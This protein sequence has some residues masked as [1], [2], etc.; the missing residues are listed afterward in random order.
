[1]LSLWW[2]R[3][4]LIAYTVFPCCLLQNGLKSWR[5]TKC[6][7]LIF[8]CLDF[9]M[10]LYDCEDEFL[11]TFKTTINEVLCPLHLLCSH[12]LDH[13]QILK[14]PANTVK[15]LEL[16]CC[17]NGLPQL[18]FFQQFGLC[19]ALLTCRGCIPEA[20]MSLIIR[21]WARFFGSAGRSRGPG[22]VSSMYWI[23]AS[24][25]S[26]HI[27]CFSAGCTNSLLLLFS[28]WIKIGLKSGG[29]TDWER[30]TPSISTAG[31][32]CIGFKALY[33]SVSWST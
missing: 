15:L 31:T 11:L 33:C 32:C 6:A 22:L 23:T 7:R 8:R 27:I 16:L 25:V 18:G 4:Y 20:I 14:N 29:L 24:Y 10:N 5:R 19:C 12:L 13:M 3:S 21:T 2:S 9:E 1:M 17:F 30:V 26:K 28:F